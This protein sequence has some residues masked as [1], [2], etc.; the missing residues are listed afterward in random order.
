MPLRFRPSFH[1]PEPRAT[2]QCI[3]HLL[4]LGAT[5]F[6]QV[7]NTFALVPAQNLR[8]DEKLISDATDAAPVVIETTTAHLY[9]TGDVVHIFG[10]FFLGGLR[11]AD[12]FTITVCG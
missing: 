8:E 10:M 7:R 1:H 4:R 11:P 5:N 6:H 12:I 2:L 9:T 3:D